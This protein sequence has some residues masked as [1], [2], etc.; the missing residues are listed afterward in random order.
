MVVNVA[1]HTPVDRALVRE[2]GRRTCINRDFD[3]CRGT[4]AAPDLNLWQTSS[5]LCFYATFEQNL[6][7]ALR[8]A[9]RRMMVKHDRELCKSYFGYPAIGSNSKPT[10]AGYCCGVPPHRDSC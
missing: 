5:H 4:K 6:I 10:Q 8:F 1:A 7:K 2:P 3:D 9:S